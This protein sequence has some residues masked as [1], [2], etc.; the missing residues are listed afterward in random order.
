MKTIPVLPPLSHEPGPASA[1]TAGPTVGPAAGCAATT[2]GS[3]PVALTASMWR[4]S[5]RTCSAA[6]VQAGG[7]GFA[8]RV[9]GGGAAC[10]QGVAARRAA[11]PSCQPSAGGPRQ[12]IA[13][14]MRAACA[15]SRL[16]QGRGAGGGSGRHPLAWACA[17]GAAASAA[18]SSSSRS[19]DRRAMVPQLCSQT[20]RRC[21][22]GARVA[23]PVRAAWHGRSPSVQGGDRHRRPLRT[24]WWRPCEAPDFPLVT[25]P[26][27]PNSEAASGG[28]WAGS[29]PHT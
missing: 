18:S 3:A 13:G 9:C 17:A 4:W 24:N 19:S 29:P 23:P 26:A 25:S 20:G 1:L 15:Q 28:A 14:R 8:C 12:A 5:R 10:V 11:A 16:V 2:A 7:R 6:A 27:L 21:T 22:Q